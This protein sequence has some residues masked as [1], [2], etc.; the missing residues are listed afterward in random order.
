MGFFTAEELIGLG[1]S[2]GDEVLVHRTALLFGS[3]IRLGS[4]IRID[5]FALLSGDVSVGNN[6]HIAAGAKIYGSSAPVVISDFAGVSANA[7]VY[8]GSDDYVDGFMTGPTVPSQF[9]K[10]K[11]GGIAMGPHSVIGV[12]SVVLPGVR[13]GYG[14]MVGGLSLVV[15]DVG[16]GEVHAGTPAKLVKHRNLERLRQLEAQYRAYLAGEVRG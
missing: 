3:Q 9:K 13:M 14:A 1:V 4:R 8:S 16:D 11:V 12:G 7:T 6:V 5:A 10:V 2:A 15:R